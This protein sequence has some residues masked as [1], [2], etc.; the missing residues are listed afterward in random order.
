MAIGVDNVHVC[1]VRSG[2]SLARGRVARASIVPLSVYSEHTR[3][4]LTVVFLINITAEIVPATTAENFTPSSTC[5]DAGSIVE[6]NVPGNC[7]ENRDDGALAILFT[8]S[9]TST[10]APTNIL[11][12]FFFFFRFKANN[13]FVFSLSRTNCN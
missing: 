10:A 3:S 13:R 5:V 12:R 4:T 8:N 6:L 7:P 9:V 2:P 11:F 1:Q